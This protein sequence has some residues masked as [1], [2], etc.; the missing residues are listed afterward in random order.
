MSEQFIYK[1]ALLKDK[2][3][4]PDDA[5]KFMC[6]LQNFT[7]ASDIPQLPPTLE[8]L[9]CHKNRLVNL[10]ELPKKL[11]KLI[12][13]ENLLIELPELPET[14]IVLKAQRNCLTELP[15]LPQNIWCVWCTYNNI[16][17][18]TPHNCQIIKYVKIL[19]IHHNPIFDRYDEKYV[20]GFRESL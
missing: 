8:V 6:Y 3:K 5:H 10:P 18:L 15:E 19:Y 13:L 9:D 20:E 4:V 1:Y 12:C 11:I 17:Y 7:N 2:T 16:K 14:L